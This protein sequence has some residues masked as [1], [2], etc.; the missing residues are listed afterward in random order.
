[1]YFPYLRGRQFELIALREYAIQR[2]DKNNVLPIIEP[3]KKSFNSLK[4]AIKQFKEHS[5]KFSL[6]VNPQVGELSGDNGSFLGTLEDELSDSDWLPAFI[7]KNNIEEI[8]QV[9]EAEGYSENVV[10]ICSKMVDTDSESFLQLVRRDCIEYIVSEEN[11]TLKRKLIKGYNKKIILLS[12]CFEPQHRNRDY[13]NMPEEKFTEEHI[14][15]DD[16]GYSGFSDYTTLSSEFSEGGSTPFAVAIH[17][18]Y[19][20]ENEEIWVRHFTSESNED[21]ANIQGKFAEAAEKAIK[22]LDEKNIQTYSADEL[23]NYY[24]EQKYPGLGMVKKISVKHHL[25]LINSI[26]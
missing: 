17:L 16:E 20:K 18:T 22:F 15:F 8:N 5:L 19:Q 21:R 3:V 6:I 7:V 14:F 11:K 24:H 13:L 2:G 1:M 10:L 12:D 23:R 26:L 4:I 9:I 25:E